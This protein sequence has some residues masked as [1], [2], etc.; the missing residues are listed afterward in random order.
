[1]SIWDKAGNTDGNFEAGGGE[2]IPDNTNCIAYIKDV[3]I[4][5]YEGDSYVNIQ[6][7]I[8]KPENYKNR[9]VF[10]KVRIFDTDPMKQEK[11][12]RMLAAID[13]NNGGKLPKDRDPSESDLVVGLSKAMMGIKVMKWEMNTK[14]EGVKTG[15]WISAVSAKAKA[16][17]ANIEIPK[18]EP[19]QETAAVDIDS[20]IPF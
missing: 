10:Q 19:V 5:E 6:W 15:N 13:H 4:K 18:S 1:M 12:I 16:A 9:V 17:A 8:L 3:G 20:D 14:Y 7:Q 11:A 2:P